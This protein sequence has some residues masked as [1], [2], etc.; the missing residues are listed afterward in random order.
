MLSLVLQLAAPEVKQIGFCQH[1]VTILQLQE[2]MDLFKMFCLMEEI[3][4]KK[5]KMRYQIVVPHLVLML[6]LLMMLQ[7]L[8]RCWIPINR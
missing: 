3:T 1:H 5:L 7:I 2:V 6:K 8:E 4:V